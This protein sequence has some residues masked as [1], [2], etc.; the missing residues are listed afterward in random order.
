MVS[1]QTELDST[2]GRLPQASPPA[3]IRSGSLDVGVLENS[4]FKAD[5]DKFQGL[6]S[7]QKQAA[8][9][10]FVL[11][12]IEGKMHSHGLRLSSERNQL[13]DGIYGTVLAGKEFRED[14]LD[15]V[16]KQAIKLAE[17]AGAVSTGEIS[18]EILALSL[19]ELERRK[20]LPGFWFSPESIVYEQR[21]KK[22]YSAFWK[23]DSFKEATGVVP[24]EDRGADQIITSGGVVPFSTYKLTPS[25]KNVAELAS[26]AAGVRAIYGYANRNIAGTNTLSDHALGKGVDIMTEKNSSEE[27]WALAR[28]LVNN[29][30]ELGIKY[31]IWDEQIWSPGRGWRGYS[32][33]SGASNA[34]LDHKDHIHVSVL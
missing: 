15:N 28:Y 4:S 18:D 3:S 22:T 31:L 19:D 24:V 9:R 14:Q 2:P 27:G 17:L 34:T 29:A 10:E 6:N 1:P 26:K 8:I 7:A 21:T 11:A 23:D 16:M 33:P 13:I 20:N 32:H 5:W 25:A 12:N 30:S